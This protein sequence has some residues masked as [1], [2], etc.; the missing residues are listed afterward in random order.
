MIVSAPLLDRQPG[1]SSRPA[2]GQPDIAV[3]GF[4]FG[5]MDMNTLMPVNRTAAPVLGSYQSV[6]RQKAGELEAHKRRL[7]PARVR[8]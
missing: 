3:C 2:F 5:F 4:N 6:L 1:P 8:L 7:H